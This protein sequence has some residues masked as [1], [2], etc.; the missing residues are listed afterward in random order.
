MTNTRNQEIDSTLKEHGKAISNLQETLA[1]MLKQQEQLMKQQEEILR[2]LKEH[3]SGGSFSGGSPDKGLFSDDS[4]TGTRP[5]RVGKVEFPRFSGEDVDGWIYRC[6][7]FFALDE[8]PDNLKLRC[9]VVHLDGEAIQWHRSFMKVRGVTV[10]NFP[11]AD[12]VSAISSRFSNAMFEDPMEELHLSFNLLMTP[13]VYKNIIQVSVAC[14]TR[15]PLANLMLLA[16][17]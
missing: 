17:I 7:H 9:A 15:L 10:M 14:L 4:R 3:S 2:A 13:R 16:Y 12:Y 5:M 1:T 8:T 6:E 11:W